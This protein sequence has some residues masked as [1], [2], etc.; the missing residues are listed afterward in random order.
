[1]RAILNKT[2]TIAADEDWRKHT[3]NFN[4]LASILGVFWSEDDA[5]NDLVI[6][7]DC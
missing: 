6:W 5:A 7:R 1:M 4:F 2:I 3:C